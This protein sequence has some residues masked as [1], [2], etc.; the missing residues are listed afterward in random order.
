MNYVYELYIQICEDDIEC[1]SFEEISTEPAIKIEN[2]KKD[3][4]VNAVVEEMAQFRKEFT[5]VVNNSSV[6]N[7]LSSFWLRKTKK[8]VLAVLLVQK[9]GQDFKLYR[10]KWFDEGGLAPE[11]YVCCCNDSL[12]SNMHP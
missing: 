8:P 12:L 5:E 6:E 2:T 3:P 7:D 11:L 1:H 9:P 10:G 4:L